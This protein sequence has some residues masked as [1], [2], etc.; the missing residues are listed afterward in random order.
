M[1][2]HL[3][4]ALRLPRVYGALERDDEG[5]LWM[6]HIVESTGR[7]WSLDHFGQAARQ[8]G[9]FDAEYLMGK[10]L[11]DYPWL[12]RPLFHDL[13][14]WWVSFMDPTLPDN[15]W[16]S[17]RVQATYTEPLRSRVLAF[18]AEVNRFCDALN[19]LPQVFCH[20][21]LNRRNLM[22]S[23]GADGLDEV[24]AFDWA[25]CG[26]GA[27]G[28]DAG[29]IIAD[30]LFFFDY[31]LTHAAEL[32]AVVFSEF[33]SGLEDLGWSGD[34]RLARLGYLIPLVA[35]MALLPGWTASMLDSDTVPMFGHAPD[36]VQTG[37]KT[38]TEYLTQHDDE[39]RQLMRELNLG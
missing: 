26:N 39:A 24:V 19:G 23:H 10:P 1:T 37:W 8:L 36:V 16:E 6:E 27:L 34:Q 5:W 13:S 29:W 14:A 2:A 32:E 12:S 35:W 30:A 7:R 3:P 21:D 25:W 15:A 31:D 22:I 11:P 18:W 28:L 9:R 4:D 33:L 17:P 20:N 38:V